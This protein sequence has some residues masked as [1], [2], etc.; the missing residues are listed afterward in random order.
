MQVGIYTTVNGLFLFSRDSWIGF[1]EH[2]R[3]YSA[4]KNIS[5]RENPPIADKASSIWP[6]EE[7]SYAFA[8]E[9]ATYGHC[10]SQLQ[11]TE[12]VDTRSSS[13]V[14]KLELKQVGHLVVA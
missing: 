2:S 11:R 7:I 8:E 14:P 1:S 4:V 3:N 10:V 6:K 9:S 13:A 5:L 12:P